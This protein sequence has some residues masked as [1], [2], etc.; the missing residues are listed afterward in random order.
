[1]KSSIECIVDGYVRLND[2]RAL[3]DLLSHREM[4]LNRL[5]GQTGLDLSGTIKQIADERRVI[6]AGI[7]QLKSGDFSCL[8]SSGFADFRAVDQSEV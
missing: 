5:G 2:R 6:E 1:M 7:R 3:E 8:S 4:L